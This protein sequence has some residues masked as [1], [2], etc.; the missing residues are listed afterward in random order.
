MQQSTRFIDPLEDRSYK[1]LVNRMTP[2]DKELY[3]TFGRGKPTGHTRIEIMFIDRVLYVYEC[4]GRGADQAQRPPKVL[5]TVRVINFYH[6]LDRGSEIVVLNEVTNEKQTIGHMPVKLFGFP[7]FVSIPCSFT[8]RWNLINVNGCDQWDSSWAV[9]VKAANKS[10]FFS[11][12]NVY[13]ESPKTMRMLY[14]KQNWAPD[15]VLDKV[16]GYA[17]R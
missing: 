11:K 12:G 3:E 5:A 15:A 8:M 1:A 16:L 2:E 17:V 9:Y 7:V 10:E 13:V 4:M 14:P 6:T